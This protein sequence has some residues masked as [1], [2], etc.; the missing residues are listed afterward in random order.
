MYDHLLGHMCGDPDDD[1]GVVRGA[2][3]RTGEHPGPASITGTLDPKTGN[4][5]TVTLSRLSYNIPPSEINTNSTET[6]IITQVTPGAGTGT[7]NYL[8]DVSL[9]DALQ[10]LVTNHSPVKEQCVATPINVVLGSSTPYTSGAVT[11]SQVNFSIPDFSTTSTCVLTR[12]PLNSRYSGNVNE[13]SLSLEGALPLPPPPAKPTTTSLLSPTPA[14]PVFVGTKVTLTASV[15]ATAGSTPLPTGHVTFKSGA[16]LLG[17]AALA[18]TG[19]TTL[20]TTVLPA[21]PTQQLTAVYSGNTKYAPSTSP[22]KSYSVQ[23]KPSVSTN[24]PATLITRTA[25][26]TYFTVRL[27]N[28]STGES[29]SSMKLSLMMSRISN[30]RPTN[31]TMTYEKFGRN[32]V[33]IP[34]LS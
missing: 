16:T 23:P 1:G 28:P 3:Q 33:P 4:I 13:M 24:L 12:T 19:K 17:R 25:T 7:I 22:A 9:T 20:I 34:A 29:F 18:V 8:G 30:E 14:G 2:W 27:T 31:V 26:P 21:K 32:M 5:S 15:A 6:I 11:I 10:V